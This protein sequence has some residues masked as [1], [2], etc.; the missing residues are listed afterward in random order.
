MA[1]PMTASERRKRL[2]LK[3]IVVSEQNY[4]ALKRLGYAGDS[5]ND[6]ISKLLRIERSYHEMKKNQQEQ[7]K[8][9]VDDDSSSNSNDSSGFLLPPTSPVMFAEQNKQLDEFVRLLRGKRRGKCSMN[10]QTSEQESK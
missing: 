6:V 2:K 10:N 7:Q 1:T 9:R 8:E 4:V 3:R 5:F